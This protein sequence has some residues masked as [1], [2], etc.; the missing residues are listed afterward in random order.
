MER[1]EIVK[2]RALTKIVCAVADATDE[3]IL[4]ACNENDKRVLEA[5]GVELLVDPVGPAWRTVVH[6]D[7]EHPDR[8]PLTCSQ[9]AERKHFIVEC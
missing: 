2:N 5:A 1:V 3:E 7:P 6:D 4:A 9:H 8:N